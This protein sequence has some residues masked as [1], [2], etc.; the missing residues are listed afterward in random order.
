M[1]CHGGATIIDHYWPS[2]DA[3]SFNILLSGLVHQS[4]IFRQT[5]LSKQCISVVYLSEKKKKK[6]NQFLKY[7]SEEQD[8]LEKRETGHSTEDYQDVESC[9][10]I[11]T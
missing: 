11:Q 2:L 1:S 9:Q 10:E 3:M 5:G 4:L 8:N 6:K 7:F